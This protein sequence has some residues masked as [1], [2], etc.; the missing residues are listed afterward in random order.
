MKPAVVLASVAVV[1]AFGAPASEASA[2]APIVFAADRAPTVTGEIYRLNANGHRVDLSRSP[3]QDLFPAVSSDGKRVAFVS[4]RGGK[5]AIYQVGIGGHNLKPLGLSVAPV[6]S[7]GCTPEL[8][9]QPNSTTLA[10]MACRNLAGSLWIVHAGQSP[11][12]VLTAK[13]GIQS[14]FAW[15]EQGLL[16][17]QVSTRTAVYD[18]GGRL[19]WSTPTGGDSRPVWSP[20]GGLLAFFT[21]N[22]TVVLNARGSQVVSKRMSGGNLAWVDDHRLAF[23]GYFGKCGCKAKILDVGTGSVSTAPRGNWF[24]PRSTDGT[25]AIV[26][27]RHGPGFTIGAAPSSGGSGRMYGSVPGCFNDGVR[28][29]S[30]GS[31]QFAGHSLVYESWFECDPPFANLYSV[32]TGIH[33]LTNAMAQETQPALS[34][35]GTEIADVWA[36]ATGLSCK[37][38]SD[39]IRIAGVDGQPVRTLTNPENCTFDESPS[40]SPDGTTIVYSENT[41]SIPNELFTISAAGGTPHDLGVAGGE[42]AWGPT[43]IAYVADG[44]WTANPDGSDPT[45]VSAHGD[46]P[47]WSPSGQLAYLVGKSVVIGSKVIQLPFQQVGS[48]RWSPDGTRLLV[49]ANPKTYR[50]FDLYSLK[51]DGT[52]LVRLTKNFGV[53]G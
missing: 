29:L 15:S 27:R 21:G 16:A 19:R 43:R 40:W 33:R 49:T 24:E 22:S 35:D 41:C 50:G 5:T 47:A 14:G 34:P 31:L 1:V 37:G 3:F 36:A 18:A 48:L 2:P 26:I 44:V 38:C 12:R 4:E 39:G 42:P 45:Q 11:I 46:S 8:G 7:A 28:Q 32:G 13:S 53:T 23:G 52:G 51:P 17:V 20:N 10:L 30:V 6:Y 25:L 9:Y